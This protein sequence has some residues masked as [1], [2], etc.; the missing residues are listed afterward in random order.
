VTELNVLPA[1]PSYD[2]DLAAERWAAPSPTTSSARVTG[3][4]IAM[5]IAVGLTVFGMLVVGYGV[6]LVGLTRFEH[7]RAQRSLFAEFN[8]GL[9]TQN[10]PVGGRIDEGA[11]VGVL[12]IP[13]IG[14]REAVSE[15]TSGG[16]LRHGPGHLRTSPFPGQLGNV[17]IAGHRI[18]Y[19]GPF[20]AI[21]DLDPGDKIRLTTQQGLAVYVVQ[22]VRPVDSGDND[23]L[24]DAGDNRL[25]LISARRVLANERVVAVARL[26]TKPVQAPPGRPTE[27]RTS[28]L[29]LHRDASSATALVLWLQLLLVAALATVWIRRQWSRTATYLVALPVLALLTLLVFDSFTPLLPSTL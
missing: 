12:E 27:L 3:R 22:Q 14:L 15:G 5:V 23:V 26:Q 18:A 7:S 20:Y 2:E 17:V 21:G 19:G 13:A 10:A 11:A 28:E 29:G 1:P 4:D 24:D 8:A 6:Y 25:T 9:A 16:V